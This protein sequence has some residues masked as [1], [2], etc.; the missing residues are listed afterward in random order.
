MTM[1]YLPHTMIARQ[2][3]IVLIPGKLAAYKWNLFKYDIARLKTLS[4]KQSFSL[5]FK[6]T[7]YI[8]FLRYQINVDL[9]I[10]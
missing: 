1:D 3:P 6:L 2:V 8:L 5:E 9:S 4:C 10:I 7:S